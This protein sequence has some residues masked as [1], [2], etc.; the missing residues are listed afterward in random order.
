VRNNPRLWRPGFKRGDAKRGR[1]IFSGRAFSAPHY[2]VAGVVWNG[3]VHFLIAQRP[4]DDTLG[5]LWEF[6]GGE[7]EPDETLED[8]LRRELV[9]S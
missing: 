7:R 6:P 1:R 9:K 8:C 2:E 3:D 5:G 4:L